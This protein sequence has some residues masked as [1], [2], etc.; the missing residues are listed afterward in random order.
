MPRI[1]K[2]Y[3]Q[4]RNEFLD[5]A[6]ELFYTHGYDQT[7]VNMI[8]E[9]VGVAKGTFYHYFDSKENLL[10]ALTDRIVKQGSA[11]LEELNQSSELGAVARLNAV[12]AETRSWKAANREVLIAIFQVI[13]RV[14]NLI[15][16]HKMMERYLELQVP[17]L[18]RIIE[19]GVRE[20]V[21][22]TVDPEGAGELILLLGSDLED[23]FARLIMELDTHPDN[24]NVIEGKIRLYEEAIERI[25]AAPQGSVH[26][27]HRG[28]VAEL[29]G[30]QA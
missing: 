4:R 30:E 2:E 17:V 11:R 10:D 7:S 22:Q 13:Y 28:F 5:A 3:D 1:T 12:F 19:Q 16:R 24:V 26:L 20:G 8:L 27:Y 18:G 21:F 15:L 25:L 14:D 23:I 9:K 6:Q 29:L